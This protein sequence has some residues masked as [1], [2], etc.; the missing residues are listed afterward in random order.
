MRLAWATD[1]H[2]DF[3]DRAR[4]AAFARAIEQT[5]AEAVVL[6]GDLSVA[7]R[8]GADLGQLVSGCRLPCYFVA[9][10]HDYYGADIAAVRRGLTKLREV[11]PR[12]RWLPAEGVVR[13]TPD[14]ALI[15]VDGWADG[16]LGDPEG[17]EVLLNDHRLIADL[18]QPSRAELLAVVRR[19]GD[20]EAA[21][22]SR[23]LGE[24][25]APCAH[26]LVATHIPPFAEASAYQGQL[27]GPAWLPWMTCHAV[28]EVL[29]EAART[30]PER[31]ITVLAG[32]THERWSVDIEPNLTVRVGRA[33]YGEPA[34]EDVLS[35]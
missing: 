7:R 2:L 23:L 33:V 28:G 26:V 31:R 22:L 25:L 11:E 24:A 35:L 4:V 5:G 34:V 1:I 16:R 3:L 29:R 6:T 21:R 30:H 10:N 13:L 9:G 18:L 32:H 14:T 8:L 20:E 27:T 12:L 19:L 17:T 15:G